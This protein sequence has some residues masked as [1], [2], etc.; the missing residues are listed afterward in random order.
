MHSHITCAGI[1]RPNNTYTIESFIDELLQKRTPEVVLPAVLG[2]NT[3]LTAEL[4][5][6]L[7][8]NRPLFSDYFTGVV[9]DYLGNSCLIDAPAAIA[10][11]PCTRAIG[12]TDM[13]ENREN[14]EYVK[15]VYG[16]E[17][18][19]RERQLMLVN[20]KAVIDYEQD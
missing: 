18:D 4:A 20:N 9:T 3:I 16:R 19:M 5:H 13:P 11:Y 10:L 15:K 2:Y 6:S 7:Q 17:I 8:R 14:V 12:E 1:S